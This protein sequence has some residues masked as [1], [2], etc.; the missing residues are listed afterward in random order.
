MTPPL[1]GETILGII[2]N[3]QKMRMMG[4]AADSYT[5]IVTD[6]RMILAQLTQAMMNTA[7]TEAQAKAKA[8]GK[9]FFGAWADQLS[10][11]FGFAKRYETM[12]PEAAL[13]ETPGNFALDNSRIRLIKVSV[14]GSND[15]DSSSNRLR[16]KIDAAEGNFEYVINEDD[17]FTAL[18]QNV[19]GDRVKMPFGLFKSGPVRIKFF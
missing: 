15:D 10:A 5:I 11:S 9:G 13:A 8:E 16:L 3:A 17:R 4:L 18:L 1:T 6:H 14:V 7:I 2:P 12:P 19:Y